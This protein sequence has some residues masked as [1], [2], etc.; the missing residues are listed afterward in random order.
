MPTV[1]SSLCCA[2][3]R[4]WPWLMDW[5]RC[6]IEGCLAHWFGSVLVVHDGDSASEAAAAA[7]GGLTAASHGAASNDKQQQQ[8]QHNGGGKFPEKTMFGFAPHG[9]YP[10]GARVAE[11]AVGRLC[12]QASVDGTRPTPCPAVVTLLRRVQA[13]ASCLGCLRSP[14]PLAGARPSRSPP[15]LCLQLP[16]SRRLPAGRASGRWVLR[17]AAVARQL[18][19][20]ACGG[21]RC[22]HGLVLRAPSLCCQP[23]S[24]HQQTRATPGVEAHAPG[25]PGGTRRCAAHPGRSG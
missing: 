15:A 14:K 11:C 6:N 19:G 2:G 21:V 5:F 13:P 9:L 8:Q 18:R 22:A 12:A 10:T 20:T 4:E 25:S 17:R 24:L 16:S 7:A 23:V 3:C 1:C